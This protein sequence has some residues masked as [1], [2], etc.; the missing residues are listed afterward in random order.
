MTT[1]FD[2]KT[3]ALRVDADGFDELVA[4]AAARP[5]GATAD[6]PLADP[7]VRAGLAAVVQP[8][9]RLHVE[10]ATRN[11]IQSHRAWVDDDAAT[12]LMQTPTPSFVVNVVQPQFVPAVLATVCRLGPRRVGDR[13]VVRVPATTADRLFDPSE[14]VRAQAFAELAIDGSKWVQRVTATWPTPDG[15]AGGR[16]VVALDG[17]CG[18][19][20][21]VPEEGAVALAPSSASDVWLHYVGLLP[22]DGEYAVGPVQDAPHSSTRGAGAVAS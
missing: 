12:F 22:Q 1:T 5:A 19:Y 11:T 14:A 2:T 21:L 10:I 13:D 17:D 18:V 16:G 9:C 20:L 6:G 7:R 8:V 4:A 15:A 3:G